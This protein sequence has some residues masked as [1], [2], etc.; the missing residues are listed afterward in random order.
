MADY[1][2]DY[3]GAQIDSAVGR[4]LSMSALTGVLTG[5]GSVVS[6][7][8]LDTS[9]LTN[10]N[11]HI[12][13]SGVVKSA[14][15]NQNLLDNAYF[16]GG[17]SQQGGGQFPIN[18]RGQA[19]YPN[20]GY[21]VDRW[22]NADGSAYTVGADGIT[23]T[24]PGAAASFVQSIEQSSELNGKTVTLSWL[25]DGVLYTDTAT[26]PSNPSGETY[27]IY[28]QY[29][30]GHSGIG[31]WY[32]TQ[33]DYRWHV[34]INATGGTAGTYNIQAAKLEFGDTQTLAHQE[35]GAWVL[36][37]IPNFQQELAKCQRYFQLFRTQSLRPTYAVDFRPVMATASPTLGTITIDG[38]TCYTASSDL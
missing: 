28:K 34:F 33:T 3:T 4:A 15:I 6:A 16:V 10:D 32:D 19:S 24:N 17:G 5:N 20:A 9:S 23:W 1:N 31:G 37:E 13:T 25:I 38:T 36:N 14:I 11:D 12:P 35:N 2:S 26:L 21:G 18:Q 8:T 22:K 29:T 27:P 7:K 30:F